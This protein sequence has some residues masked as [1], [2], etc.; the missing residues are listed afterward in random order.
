MWPQ[1]KKTPGH[2]LS[3]GKPTSHVIPSVSITTVLQ[4]LNVHHKNFFATKI[5]EK[6]H[7]QMF[8]DFGCG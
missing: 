6:L 2:D 8:F 1:M 4:G 5:T 3:R 7:Q